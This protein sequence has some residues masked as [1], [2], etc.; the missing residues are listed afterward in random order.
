MELDHRAARL[1]RR[2]LGLLL[3]PQALS[4]GYSPRQIRTNLA[5]GAWGRDPTRRVRRGRRR[6]SPS[7]F[8][9]TTAGSRTAPPAACLVCGTL[10]RSDASRRAAPTVDTVASVGSSSDGVA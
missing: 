3:H 8:P 4:I 10:L 5:T 9:S 2:Q 1:A 6:C 7:H